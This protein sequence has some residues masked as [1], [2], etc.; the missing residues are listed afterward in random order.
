MFIARLPLL[1]Q[2]FFILNNIQN[3]LT[4][5]PNTGKIIGVAEDAFE[6]EVIYSNFKKMLDQE[7]ST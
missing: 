4:L 6:L 2:F 7:Q 1:L 3:R 5:C